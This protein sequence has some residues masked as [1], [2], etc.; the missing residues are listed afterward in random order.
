MTTLELADTLIRSR[1]T[2]LEILDDRGYDTTAYQNIAPEQI[3][4]LSESAEGRALDVVVPRKDVPDA[5]KAA[6][7][8]ERAV[9]TY[10]IQSAISNR[11]EGTFLRDLYDAP[12]DTTGANRI[13]RTDD[14]IVLYNEPTRD[15]F[16]KAALNLWKTQKARVTFF[17]IKQVVV[18][19]GRHDLVPP[20]RKLS[21]EEK[22]ALMIEKYLRER[23][24]LPL[25]K[26]SDIQAKL[27]GLIPGDIV[28]IL[29]PSPTAGVAPYWRLCST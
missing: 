2:I 13:L 20:H 9:V 25:I 6:A 21:E 22:E 19:L 3:I 15:V 14:V 29:R 8:S 5:G 12:P 27:L 24:Q 17:H 7:P 16:D 26:H 1:H 28:E 18:H 23:S 10:C 4:L 11:L